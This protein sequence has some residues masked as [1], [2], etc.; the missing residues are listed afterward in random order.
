MQ[1]LISSKY[2]VWLH[3][4][5]MMRGSEGES[6]QVNR[7]DIQKDMEYIELTVAGNCYNSLCFLLLQVVR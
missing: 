7:L 3:D 1:H 6:L 4:W 5:V 2:S